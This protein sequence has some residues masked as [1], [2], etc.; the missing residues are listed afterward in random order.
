MFCFLCLFF[1]RALEAGWAAFSFFCILLG[2]LVSRKRTPRG[3]GTADIHTHLQFSQRCAART[4]RQNYCQIRLWTCARYQPFGGPAL[5]VDTDKHV[6]IARVFAVPKNHT[7]KYIIQ[8]YH[9]VSYQ[10]CIFTQLTKAW[11][12]LFVRFSDGTKREA[13]PTKQS[14]TWTVPPPPPP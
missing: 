13:V 12:L 3:K 10:A 7:F 4:Q 5:H 9:I 6:L 11:L 2:L 8:T 14:S 1:Q